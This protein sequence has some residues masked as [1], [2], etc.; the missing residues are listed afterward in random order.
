MPASHYPAGSPARSLRDALEPLAA[1]AFWSAAT[2][3]AMAQLGLSGTSGYVRGR[4]AALGAPTAPV[5]ISAFAW[6]EPRL[7]ESA[8]QACPV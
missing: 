2:R 1:H 6:F 7:I 8:Y 3:Q 4:A 5:V